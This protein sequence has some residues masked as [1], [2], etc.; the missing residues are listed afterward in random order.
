MSHDLFFRLGSRVR[1]L[2]KERNISQE[3]LA[4]KAGTSPVY[5][6]RIESGLQKPSLQ[7]LHR[8]ATAMKVPLYAFF[9]WGRDEQ[10]FDLACRL[11]EVVARRAGMREREWQA[12]VRGIQQGIV[13]ELASQL[14]IV[15]GRYEPLPETGSVRAAESTLAGEYS[16]PP[17][18]TSKKRK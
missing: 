5:L 9:L 1:R 6:S 2:R 10:L 3:H 4:E 17:R 15:P 13:D 16:H 8:L 12:L 7:T 14:G 18:S 11:R